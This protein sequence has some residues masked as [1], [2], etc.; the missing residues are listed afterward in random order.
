MT[1]HNDELPPPPPSPPPPTPPRKTH[2][3]AL[4]IQSL[5]NL[6]IE[7]RLKRNKA[8]ETKNLERLT[9]AAMRPAALEENPAD[10]EFL[11]PPSPTASLIT[12]TDEDI[13]EI[14]ELDL[15]G[16]YKKQDIM[17]T[18]TL[19]RINLKIKADGGS[20]SADKRKDRSDDDG[21]DKLSKRQC[22]DG[23]KITFRAP[24]DPTP[25]NFPEVMFVTQNRVAWLWI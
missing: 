21:S 22:M 1:Q 18:S 13:E 25:I 11:A 8:I 12:I 24:G 19:K 23:D 9:Y 4:T 20:G 14:I 10:P 7:A 16:V 5:K 15:V 2:K 17:P 3:N 6:P